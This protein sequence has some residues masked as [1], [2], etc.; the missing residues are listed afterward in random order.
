MNVKGILRRS[1]FL[2]TLLMMHGAGVSIPL[3][4]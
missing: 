2:K 3:A 4:G 1:I